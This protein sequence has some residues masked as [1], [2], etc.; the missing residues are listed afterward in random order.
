MIAFQINNK[1]IIIFKNI[2]ENEESKQDVSREIKNILIFF[3]HSKYK[4]SFLIIRNVIN[5]C[6]LFNVVMLERSITIQRDS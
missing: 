3:F 4:K 1:L 2:G 5:Y 6:T